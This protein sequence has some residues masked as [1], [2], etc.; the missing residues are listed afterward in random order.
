VHPDRHNGRRRVPQRTEPIPERRL[1]VTFH[2]PSADLVLGRGL[3]T[4]WR[5]L[6]DAALVGWSTSEPVNM[7]GGRAS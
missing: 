5:H 4:A 3:E 7:P 1:A 6:T 2:T